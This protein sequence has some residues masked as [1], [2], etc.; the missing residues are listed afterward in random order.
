[1]INPSM[2]QR[3]STLSVKSPLRLFLA[4]S[5]LILLLALFFETAGAHANLLDAI[6]AA[7][8]Q[9]EKP[10][11]LVEL[12]FSEAIE[13]SFSTIEVLDA[14][15]VR[16]DND[17]SRVDPV[18]PLRLSVTLRSLPDGVYT[19]SWRTLSAVDSHITAG[20]FPF[21]VG[22]VDSAELES[23]ANIDQQI[24]TSTGEIIARWLTYLS[25]MAVTG[26]MFFL[27][28]VWR[29]SMDIAGIKNE[30][31]LPWRRFG[32]IALLILLLASLLWLLIQAGQAAGVAIAAPWSPALRQ[33]LFSTRFGVLW[34]ARVV[35]ILAALWLVQRIRSGRQQWLIFAAGFLILLTISM[36]SH[37]AAEPKPL[38][39]IIADWIHLIAASLWIGGLIQFA[40]ALWILK[41]AAT[42]IRRG[43]TAILIPRFSTAA[44]LSVGFIAL[45]GSYAS[46]LHV[47]SLSSFI[48]TAY[49]RTLLLKLAFFLPMVILG[50]IN[51]L[52]TTPKMK[53]AA[54]EP[55]SPSPVPLFRRLLSSE[56]TFGILVLL[57][58]ALLTTLPP[59]SVPETA[60]AIG[61]TQATE[62]LEISLEVSPGRPGLNSFQ[63]SVTSNGEALS[64]VRDVSIQ[65]TPTT[66]ELPPSSVKLEEQEDGIFSTEGG[67]LAVADTW[68][69]Q[70]AVRRE[71]AFDSFANFE[72]DIGGAGANLR[73]DTRQ[74]IPWHRI[75]GLLTVLAGV[76]LVLALAAAFDLNG[77]AIIAAAVPAVMIV[78]AGVVVFFDIPEEDV[79]A[80][81]NPIPP[82]FDSLAAGQELYEANCFPCHGTSGA[83]DGP[84]GITLNPPPADLT[85][86]TAPGVHP[87][88]QLYEW[89]TNGFP[90]SV[91]PTFG[92]ILSD[93]ERWNVVNYIRTLALP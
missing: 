28:V 32:T 18:N 27:I 55:G 38:I 21:A 46:F 6:P 39:P 81:V 90:G 41:G 72:L 93:E 84:V 43:I 66:I 58:V 68:Q 62:D 4:A 35:L 37:A 30:I 29:P 77:K 5:F 76:M 88:G 64:T 45:T 86:H 33:V 42:R 63:I 82:N 9:L 53:L 56:V 67:Y 13:S 48:S 17:D 12:F 79:L 80:L 22:D 57:S 26:G 2:V 83:G 59:A 36:G 7:N 34:L 65:F 23:A 20:V 49:G 51:L 16:V 73:Q 74:S 71:D 10:P 87:D 69:A 75:A 70:V 50:A 47:G 54:D 25:T 8:E 1:L 15:G 92:D 3:I 11:A 44:L 52:R 61:L 89:V 60:P 19:V 31:R 14:S 91:M 78:A 40:I 85:V 24:T